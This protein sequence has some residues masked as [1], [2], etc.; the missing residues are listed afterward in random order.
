MSRLSSSTVELPITGTTK[1]C[2]V[3]TEYAHWFRD[4]ELFRHPERGVYFL[5]GERMYW[6]HD[7]VIAIATADGHKTENVPPLAR[8]RHFW[9]TNCTPEV[10]QYCKR[11]LE[12]VA[13]MCAAIEQMLV[14]AGM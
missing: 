8:L 2:K 10:R 11:K 13:T 4:R 1:T 3:D 6:V 9:R 7:Q 5:V 14:V 12:P